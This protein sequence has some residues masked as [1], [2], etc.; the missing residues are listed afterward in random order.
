LNC[1]FFII[2]NYPY[3]GYLYHPLNSRDL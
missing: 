3:I 2:I 1:T